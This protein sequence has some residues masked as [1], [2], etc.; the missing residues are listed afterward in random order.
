MMAQHFAGNVRRFPLPVLLN[1]DRIGREIHRVVMTIEVAKAN[2]RDAKTTAPT[3]ERLQ[4]G[5]VEQYGA[6]DS[7]GEMGHRVVDACL[8]DALYERGALLVGKEDEGA[9]RRRHSA[10]LWLRTLF[11]ESGLMRGITALLNS[12]GGGSG[13]PERPAAYEASSHASECLA[14]YQS[15]IWRMENEIVPG[16]DSRITA[17]RRRRASHA[18]R[19]IA[20]WDRWPTAFSAQEVRDAFDRLAQ[21]EG[22]EVEGEEIRSQHA[23]QRDTLRPP[24]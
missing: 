8:L 14:R 15:V 13:N 22:V 16:D 23:G 10:G 21:M 6:T 3:L 4:H 1:L 20:C 18:V 7:A 9:A 17:R 2:R 5:A 12:A 24:C 11:H 19:E